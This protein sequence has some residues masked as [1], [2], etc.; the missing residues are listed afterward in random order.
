[1]TVPESVRLPVMA[2]GPAGS[3][4]NV[5]PELN[6]T[7]PKTE[8]RPPK[9]APDE[10]VTADPERVPLRMRPPAET[11]VAPVCELIER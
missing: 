8:P 11:E 3:A 2:R 1:M 4:R 7:L 6:V 5:E 10:T 9:L